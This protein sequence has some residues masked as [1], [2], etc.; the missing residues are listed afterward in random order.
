MQKLSEITIYNNVK[1]GKIA[2]T[3]K[4]VRLYPQYGRQ[5]TGSHYGLHFSVSLLLIDFPVPSYH[6]K[7]TFHWL[8]TLFK[9]TAKYV[10]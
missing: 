8:L 1:R 5:S 3:G 7:L 10:Q 4:C 2:S 9:V 6:N